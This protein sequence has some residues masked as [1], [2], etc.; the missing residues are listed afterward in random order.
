MDSPYSRFR[1]NNGSTHLFPTQSL[2][3]PRSAVQCLAEIGL[4][5][6][7][8]CSRLFLQ[9]MTMRK[10]PIWPATGRPCARLHNPPPLAFPSP[11]KP[12][13]ESLSKLRY[14]F[15]LAMGRSSSRP[16]SRG[17]GSTRR[18][19]SLVLSLLDI[20]TFRFL[21]CCG[22]HK[23][24]FGTPRRIYLIHEGSGRV[25]LA[26]RGLCRRCEPRYAQTAESVIIVCTSWTKAFLYGRPTSIP[27]PSSARASDPSLCAGIRTEAPV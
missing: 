3:A 6:G 22:M 7:P 17:T 25:A 1:D 9:L 14:R 5:S 27:V 21:N 10:I 19:C 12:R 8:L 18:V 24:W 15:P 20:H 26:N 4:A 11:R 2:Q 13:A 16:R 23:L